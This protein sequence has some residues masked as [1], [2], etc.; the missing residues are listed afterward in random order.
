MGED[1]FCT[2]TPTL[3]HL[4]H[5]CGRYERFHH[6]L[7]HQ[8][9]RQQALGEDEV[10]E[11][12]PVEGRPQAQ[13]RVGAQLHQAQVAAEVGSGLAGR[14]ERVA[15]QLGLRERLVGLMAA[16]QVVRPELH[17][18]AFN[19]GM[20][21]SETALDIVKTIIRVSDHPELEPIILNE[22]RNEVQDQ[23]MNSEKASRLLGWEP[24]AA[25][26]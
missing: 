9:G 1:A 19:F 20:G 4:F 7:P 2:R 3:P 24:Q 22:V 23:F 15:L 6:R 14:A 18:Q 26:G 12:L 16:E 17:G 25:R 8:R 11:R 21:H 10:V 5:S 13:L